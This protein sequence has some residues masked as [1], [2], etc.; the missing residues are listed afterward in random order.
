[1][2]APQ[3]LLSLLILSSLVS[4]AFPR[5]PTIIRIPSDH[6]GRSRDDDVYCDSWRFSVET[7][8]AGNWPKVPSRCVSFVRD[9]MTGEKYRS[10]SEVVALNS[11]AF[12]KTVDLAADGKDAWVFD[13]DET[14]L[15]NLPYYESHGFGSEHF[16]ESS[17]DQWVDLAAAPALPASLNLYKELKQMGFT[18]ILLTGRSEYQ[19]NATAGNL[20]SAGY[21]D[22]KRLILRYM[23]I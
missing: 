13:I 3:S 11:L 20:I 8:D 14:L 22:W 16:N 21:G 10:D 7:N 2:A 23:I 5:Q 12:A 1:M 19:R 4:A 9:Y 6:D 17:F 15:S 18:L